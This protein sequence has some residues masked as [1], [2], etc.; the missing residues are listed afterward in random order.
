ML[1]KSFYSLARTEALIFVASGDSLTLKILYLLC[2]GASPRWKQCIRIVCGLFDAESIVFVNRNRPN[3]LCANYGIWDHFLSLLEENRV[4]LRFSGKCVFQ[5]RCWCWLCIFVCTRTVLCLPVSYLMHSGWSGV[6]MCNI[7]CTLNALVFACVISH[8][9]W[10]L[11]LPL[12]HFI[13]SE[14]PGV[15]LYNI[16]HILA[17]L[18]F[19]NVIVHTLC[20]LSR[21]PVS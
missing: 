10:L 1:E 8:A 16:K 18:V 4:F 7:C 15:R 13:H 2:L 17:A 11:C 14:C 19:D 6:C 12:W 5:I 3:A 20:L 21:L 9:L